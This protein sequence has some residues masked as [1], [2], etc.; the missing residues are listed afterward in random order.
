M[1]P[2]DILTREEAEEA[3]IEVMDEL[4]PESSNDVS[5][6]SAS[7]NRFRL[8]LVLPTLARIAHHP[9]LVQLVKDALGCKEILLW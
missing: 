9:R 6:S 2:L 7:P 1:G 5:D 8:H 3:L 4:C